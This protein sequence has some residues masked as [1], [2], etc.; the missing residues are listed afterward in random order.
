MKLS[1]VKLELERGESFTFKLMRNPSC[2][3]KWVVWIQEPSGKSYFLLDDCNEVV[4]H[5]D[6]NEVFVL[7]RSLGVRAAQVML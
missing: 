4:S 2:V 1:E 7:L 5:S 6:A 3:L